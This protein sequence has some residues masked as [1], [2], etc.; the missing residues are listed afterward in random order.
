MKRI[1]SYLKSVIYFSLF[2]LSF[3]TSSALAQDAFY[4]YRNDGDFNGFFFDQVKRMGY[5]KV[6]FEGVEHDVY[7]VQEIETEDTLYRIPLAAIDSIGFQQPEIRLNPRFKDLR[8]MGKNFIMGTFGTNNVI[9]V[10]EVDSPDPVQMTSLVTEGDVICINTREDHPYEDG[11]GHT[12]PGTVVAPYVCK[13]KSVSNNVIYY[14]PITSI[15]EVFEQFITVE[16]LG[17]DKDGNAMSRMAGANQLRRVGGS[18]DLT[19]VDINNRIGYGFEPK[20]GL[21]FSIGA[22][23]ELKTAAQAVYNV[24]WSSGIYLKLSITDEFSFNL[25][26]YV[27]Y[28]TDG[29]DNLWEAEV[30]GGVPVMLPSFLPLFELRPIPGM[31]LKAEGHV[32]A[33]ITSPTF[34]SS[35]TREITIDS[36]QPWSSVVSSR[37]KSNI[38]HMTDADNS[39]LFKLSLDGFVQLGIKV[40]MRIYTCSWAKE[41]LEMS[42]GADLYMGPKL[43]A[44]FSLDLGGAAA[45][46]LYDALSGTKIELSPLAIDA[47]TSATFK[48]PDPV[49]WGQEYSETFKLM[50]T[51]VSL[52]PLTLNLL[53]TFESVEF[54]G[55]TYAVAPRGNYLPCQIGLSVFDSKGRFVSYGSTTNAAIQ[56]PEHTY[57]AWNTIDKV[58]GGLR[59]VLLPGKYK[60]YPSLYMFNHYMIAMSNGKDYTH[61]IGNVGF[62]HSEGTS[63]FSSSKG[64]SGSIYVFGIDDLVTDVQVTAVQDEIEGTFFAYELEGESEPI[65]PEL[66]YQR[67]YFSS[68]IRNLYESGYVDEMIKNHNFYLPK[69]KWRKL[70][71]WMTGKRDDEY[72]SGS[73]SITYTRDGVNYS[74]DISVTYTPPPKNN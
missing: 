15:G 44:S 65:D 25:S 35:G 8:E 50:E 42:I 33:S 46:S 36:S 26:G 12:T 51:G 67:Y 60:I 69:Y 58:E 3:F 64:Y 28:K 20:P 71:Y 19:L 29:N 17:F 10:Y 54:D 22:N 27:D 14:E 70:R 47:V 73:I 39:W 74:G 6:D 48:G 31:F 52:T 43:S 61:H 63:Q 72:K 66:D 53:P 23:A 34:S 41:L 30:P 38:K 55:Y 7:V 57:S 4:I 13:V 59:S 40:P 16:Q 62:T 68:S 32:T 5:S 37:Y 1:Y 11:T 18:R 56:W 49:N 9:R 24:G 21:S 45:G 2:T